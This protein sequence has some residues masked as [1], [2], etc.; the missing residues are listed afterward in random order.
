LLSM[1]SAACFFRELAKVEEEKIFV[2]AWNAKQ[3]EWSHC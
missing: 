3:A 1:L 2:S